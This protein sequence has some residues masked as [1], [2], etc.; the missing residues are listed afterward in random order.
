MSKQ[1]KNDMKQITSKSHALSTANSKME[2]KM[3]E[4][5]NKIKPGL[6]KQRTKD[7]KDDPTTTSN[8]INESSKIEK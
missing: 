3:K 5:N 1:K 4:S 8:G 6:V 7:I 2:A